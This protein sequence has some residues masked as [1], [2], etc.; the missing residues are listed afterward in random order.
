MFFASTKVVTL[1]CLS[2]SLDS[3]NGNTVNSSFKYPVLISV[4]LPALQTEFLCAFAKLRKAS[5]SVMSV[6]PFVRME[7]PSPHWTSF[8]EI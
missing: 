5:I 1:Y 8:R 7:Q 2:G 6:R 3:G 4:G